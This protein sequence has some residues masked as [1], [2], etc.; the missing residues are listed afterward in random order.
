MEPSAVKEKATP[1]IY[2]AYHGTE[3]EIL[4]WCARV[5]VSFDGHTM[6]VPWN[7]LN[8][9]VRRENERVPFVS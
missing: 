2:N 5:R 3:F 4:P 8:D 6:D 9:F 7:D 1:M